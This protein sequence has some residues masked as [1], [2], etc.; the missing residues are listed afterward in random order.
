LCAKFGIKAVIEC[1]TGDSFPDIT[2]EKTET[3][4]S[5][6]EKLARLR[7]VLITD[8]ENGDLVITQAGKKGT[9]TDSLVEGD[10][11]FSA[12]AK[13][14]CHERFQQYAVYS[15]TPLS[16]DGE[17]SHSDII[18]TATD[19]ACP[20]YRR[21]AEQAED[22]SDSGLAKKRA[23]WRAKHNAAIGTEA[24]ITVRG[25]RQQRGKLW[26]TN[27]LVSVTS[28]RLAVDRTL[29]I[30]KVVWTISESGRFTHITVA[31]QE[32]FT[33]EPDAATA[34]K[35]KGKTAFQWNDTP[36]NPID[37]KS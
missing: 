29:L 13:L 1:D 7:Q 5:C 36:V 31:P 19:P 27:F 26:D 9:S 6:L 3:A 4:F 18:G 2:V 23:L 10:N 12:T 21:F 15:Q 30:S 16:F 11:I 35:S 34:P 25:F 33:P 17:D 32:A 14:D 20:R 8:N 28:P 22:P 37:G 24:T